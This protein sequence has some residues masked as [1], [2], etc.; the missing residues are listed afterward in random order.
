MNVASLPKDW[1]A[2]QLLRL[3]FQN[4]VVEERT[5]IR[6]AT[7]AAWIT[8]NDLLH[9]R[10]GWMESVI[11]SPQLLE[12]FETMMTPMGFPIDSS[13]FYDPLSSENGPQVA[14]ERHNVDKN[15]LAQDLTLVSQDTVWK[16]RIAAATAM[17]YLVASWNSSVR[18]DTYLLG[19]NALRE[20]Q[21]HGVD[22]VFQSILLHYV[23]SSSMMQKVLAAI[24]I[25][26]WAK[27]YDAGSITSTRPPLIEVSTLAR[28]MSSRTLAWLQSEPPTAYHEM[29]FT[30]ARIH[31]ECTN[32]LHSFAFDCKIPW[33]EI[34]TLGTEIDLTGSKQG[35]FSLASAEAAVEQDY[36]K[37]RD[38]VGKTKKR[39]L[40]V[41]GEKRKTVISSIERYKE[42]KTQHDI[43]VCAAFAAAYV[44]LKNT[45]D[46]VS[47][48]VKGVMNGIKVC[49]VST[50]CTILELF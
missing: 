28:E 24:V 4:L 40:A 37:L 39:E 6:D 7:A 50:Y 1:V 10:P 23:D 18:P 31:G 14:P 5:D 42:V 43:R 9:G 11:T 35:G 2:T 45:P 3:L 33:A 27:H 34:P 12:W 22:S 30:L 49:I 13:G 36:A 19:D 17:A 44:A 29:A 46:K 41:I 38:R 48:I 16:A 20:S 21:A 47:P 32:L 26:E 15:M 25:E 8:A